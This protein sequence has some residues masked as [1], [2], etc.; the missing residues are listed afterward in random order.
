MGAD[1][2][3]QGTHNCANRQLL[4]ETLRDDWGFTGH[5]ISDGGAVGAMADRAVSNNTAVR[6]NAQFLLQP[7]LDLAGRPTRWHWLAPQYATT[8]EAASAALR[9]GCDV[10]MGHAFLGN[11]LNKTLYDG[12]DRRDGIEAMVGN[13]SITIDLVKRAVKR[14]CMQLGKG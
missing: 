12:N 14:T 13:G 2:K 10:A 6:P 9:A 4:T 8:D 3:V 5:V 11:P 7:L 1:N